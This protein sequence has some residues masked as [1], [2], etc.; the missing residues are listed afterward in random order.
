MEG[1]KVGVVLEVLQKMVPEVG[2]NGEPFRNGEGP[3]FGGCCGDE[4]DGDWEVIGGGVEMVKDVVGVA[5]FGVASDVIV[6]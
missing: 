5:L 6:D 2:S 3:F 4:S 1:V